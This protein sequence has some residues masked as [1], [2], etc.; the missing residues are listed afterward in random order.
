MAAN[1]AHLD[2][3]VASGSRPD[4]ADLHVPKLEATV[5]NLG[6]ESEAREEPFKP[7]D[8]LEKKTIS[9]CVV[10]P[11]PDSLSVSLILLKAGGPRQLTRFCYCCCHSS[12][13]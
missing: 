1:E 8:K 7:S 12:F 5:I 3:A 2:R 10:R 4:Q 11:R 6:S 13:F 9:K